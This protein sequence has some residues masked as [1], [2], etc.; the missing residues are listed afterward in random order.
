MGLPHSDVGARALDL[1]DL[2]RSPKVSLILDLFFL[3]APFYLLPSP[4]NP[5][6]LGEGD[7]AEGRGGDGIRH[8]PL[9]PS[10][11][12]CQL[13]AAIILCAC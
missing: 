6:S 8:C 11:Q 7:G 1:L 12:V 5:E 4:S 9:C 10:A 13:C 3:L 2:V